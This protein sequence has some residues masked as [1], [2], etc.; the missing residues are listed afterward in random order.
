LKANAKFIGVITLASLKIRT[1]WMA[2][3]TVWQ[4]VQLAAATAAFDVSTTSR[5][6]RVILNARRTVDEPSRRLTATAALSPAF[7]AGGLA[8]MTPENGRREGEEQ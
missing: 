2:T 5:L 4:S 8:A 3:A 7:A 1:A 6:T